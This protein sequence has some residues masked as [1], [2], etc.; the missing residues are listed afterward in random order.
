MKVDT[1][2]ATAA[3]QATFRRRRIE[4]AVKLLQDEGFHVELTEKNPAPQPIRP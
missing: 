4:K 1:S 2:R 3:S